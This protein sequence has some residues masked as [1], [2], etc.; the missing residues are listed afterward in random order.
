VQ[1]ERRLKYGEGIASIVEE[2]ISKV[3]WPFEDGH[4]ST[5]NA[6]WEWRER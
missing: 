5:W 4:S 3:R 1:K 6:G 2:M